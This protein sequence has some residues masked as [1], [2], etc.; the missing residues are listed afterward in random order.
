MIKDNQRVPLTKRLLT[1]VIDDLYPIILNL[2]QK[3]HKVDDM[4]SDSLILITSYYA[5]GIYSL[6]R[7]WFLE[8][9]PKPPT[10]I[11]ELLFSYASIV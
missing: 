11:T 3:G 8:D 4:D 6:L 1:L 9:V 10:E 7:K 5:G 2:T